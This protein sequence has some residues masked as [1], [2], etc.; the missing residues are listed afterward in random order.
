VFTI[1]ETPTFIRR[2]EKL[3]SNA[4]RDALIDFL[5]ANPLAGDVMPETGGVRK[6]RFSARGKGK[7]GGVRMIYYLLD[8]DT[9]LYALLI[10][11]KDEQDNL[12]ADQKK[13]GPGFR[14][15]DQGRKEMTMVSR[16][17]DRA[18]VGEELIQS[19][20]EAL[21]HA[22][23]DDV[24]VRIT[25]F[26]EPAV[27]VRRIRKKIG[28][29]QEH[30]AAALGVSVSGLRKWEQGQRHPHGAALTLLRIMDSEP[31]A[32]SRAIKAA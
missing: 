28:L 29:T 9:P 24:P 32:V 26:A 30:F 16:K 18:S 23:G 3:L 17:V 15:S 12:T 7:R 6:V 5:A 14:G 31:E 11:G 8:E 13:G 4:D 2:A 25:E 22:R 27:E 20:Q 19:L 1:V 10:Y 21:A